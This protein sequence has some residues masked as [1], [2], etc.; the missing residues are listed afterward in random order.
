MDGNK[1]YFYLDLLR[2]F[3]ILC[4]IILHIVV[5]YIGNTD[6]FGTRIW[7][8]ANIF[9]TISRTGVPIFFMVSGFLLLNSSKTADFISFYKRRLTKL[10][11][12]FL[13]WNVIYYI[14]YGLLENREISF[15]EFFK[16]MLIE[17]TSY[18]FWFVYTLIVIYLFMP[19]LKRILDGLE[20]KWC[21][22]LLIISG[23]KTTIVPFINIVTPLEIYMFDNILLGYV[24]YVLLG[25]IL[26]K[27]EYTKK[28]KTIFGFVGIV[29]GFITTLGNYLMSDGATNLIFNGGYQI[30]HFMLAAGI[31]VLFKSF[32][33]ASEKVEK[34]ISVL[35]GITFGMY[36]VHPLVITLGYEFIS[37]ELRPYMH[38]LAMFG[39]TVVVSA[40]FTY[41]ISKIRIINKILL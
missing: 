30:G 37:S 9:N 6:L 11:V 7:H 29:G 28:Q 38:I 39:F 15:S 41:L 27:F 32:G 4:V 12:P 35:S 21:W 24:S 23:I 13:S 14:A 17:G 1:K 3:A 20:Q 40:L 18:H 19:F 36:L 33:R 10:A 2:I 8:I 25:Y 26:G 34:V 22:L 31:F 5:P 16:Q